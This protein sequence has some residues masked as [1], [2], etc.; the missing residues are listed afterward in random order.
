MFIY[1]GI[2]YIYMARPKND[3]RPDTPISILKTQKIRMRKYAKPDT[4]RKG[5]ESDRVVFERILEFYEQANPV[6]NDSIPTYSN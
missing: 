2:K 6:T 3:N 4:K 1:N 5:N